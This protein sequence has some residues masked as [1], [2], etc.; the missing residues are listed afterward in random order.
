MFASPFSFMRKS[1]TDSW[2]NWAF[3]DLD[4]VIST[5]PFEEL[6]INLS[7]TSIRVS[8]EFY[9]DRAS[10]LTLEKIAKYNCFELNSCLAKSTH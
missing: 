6:S 2:M 4:F 8:S 7:I 3:G 1:L 5:S 9:L 10:G